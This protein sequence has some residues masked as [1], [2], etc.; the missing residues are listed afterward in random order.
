MYIRTH[1]RAYTIYHTHIHR[2]IQNEGGRLKITWRVTNC[3]LDIQWSEGDLK[4]PQVGSVFFFLYTSRLHSS[5]ELRHV[6]TTYLILKCYVKIILISFLFWLVYPFFS[7]VYGTL[8]NKEIPRFMVDVLKRLSKLLRFISYQVIPPYFSCNQCDLLNE[9]VLNNNPVHIK[10]G[11]TQEVMD[12][13]KIK[14]ILTIIHRT[15][16]S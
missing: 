13:W 12:E 15:R 3:I 7:T 1:V 2:N 6:V 9:K 5:R 10:R 16:I 4:D 14:N 11:V 8:S